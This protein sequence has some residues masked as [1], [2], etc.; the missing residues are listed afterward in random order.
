MSFL[1]LCGL[2]GRYL[3]SERIAAESVLTGCLRNASGGVA[4]KEPLKKAK[5]P[6][7]RFDITEEKTKDVLQSEKDA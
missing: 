1:R 6:Q 5:T 3:V 7:G 4:D 2:K